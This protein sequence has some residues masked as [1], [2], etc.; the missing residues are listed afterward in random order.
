M[1][2]NVSWQNFANMGSSA[3]LTMKARTATNFCAK[4]WY[5]DKHILELDLIS[6]AL[7]EK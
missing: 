2:Y 7:S 3:N 6:L 4:V 1:Y 5:Q